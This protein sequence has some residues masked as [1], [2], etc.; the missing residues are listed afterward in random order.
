MDSRPAPEDSSREHNNKEARL[1]QPGLFSRWTGML[2]RMGLGETLLRTGTH[3]F[4][5]LAL[6]GVIWLTQSLYKQRALNPTEPTP[7]QVRATA[8]V[9]PEVAS[10]PADASSESISRLAQLHTTIPSRPRDEIEKYTVVEGDTVFGIAEKFGL[11]P[12]T[13]LWGN[14][15]T[16]L[17]D[18]HNLRPGQVL[19]ILPVD[20]TYY[21]WQNGDGLNG[22]ATFFGVSPEVIVN[23]PGNNLDPA[24]IGDFAAPNIKAGT[25]LIVPG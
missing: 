3:I 10:A 21:E 2:V 7:E 11:Q 25:Y 12:Q 9:D 6:V 18:P 8:V 13:I 24:T 17:D 19:N 5:V 20:G 1:G 14:Y 23:Y 15:G 16:L 22:V 4:S